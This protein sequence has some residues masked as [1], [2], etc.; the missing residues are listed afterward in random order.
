M[1]APFDLE[2]LAVT[3]EVTRSTGGVRTFNSWSNGVFSLSNDGTLVFAPGGRLGTDRTLVTV[4]ASGRVT[5]FAADARSYENA[6]AISRDGQHVAVVISNAKG[7]YETWVAEADRPGLR[8]GRFRCP[9]PT[10]AAPRGRRTR[11]G[12][13]TIAMARDTDDGIYL[14]RAD[15]TGSPRG[16]PQGRLPRD[17]PFGDVVVLPT[18]PG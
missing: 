16:D 18:G 4:D 3:G 6:P 11:S 15:G 14:Q 5:R 13:R 10:A 12:W 1:A 7:T 8:P 17:R 9:T 2:T